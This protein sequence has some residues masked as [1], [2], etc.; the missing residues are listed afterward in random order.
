MNTEES[1]PI[2]GLKNPVTSV[3]LRISTSIRDFS[4][5]DQHQ[6]QKAIKALLK[7]HAEVQ[8]SDIRI[9]SLWLSIELKPDQAEQLLQAFRAGALKKFNVVD[10]V[11]QH[12]DGIISGG[13]SNTSISTDGHNGPG[14]GL[15]ARR[16]K[17]LSPAE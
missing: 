12:I 17:T 5:E 6:L 3:D 9:G 15:T 14:I 16:T 11:I 4:S 8:I 10:A 1:M 2:I 13:L 7:T